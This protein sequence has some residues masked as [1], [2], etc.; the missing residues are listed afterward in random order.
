[1]VVGRL[2]T[3]FTPGGWPEGVDGFEAGQVTKTEWGE[4]V[5]GENDV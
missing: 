5:E 1:M 4:Q 3:D 2:P